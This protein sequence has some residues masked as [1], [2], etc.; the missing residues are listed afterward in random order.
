MK[1]LPKFFRLVIEERSRRRRAI[2]VVC[3]AVALIMGF[4]AIAMAE[5]IRVGVGYLIIIALCIVQYRRPTLFLWFLVT[6][7]FLLNSILLLGGFPRDPE[8]LLIMTAWAIPSMFL[9]GSW[10]RSREKSEP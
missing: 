9:L 5:D 2:Y 4:L 3:A 7:V 6:A 1:K 10:P 8:V